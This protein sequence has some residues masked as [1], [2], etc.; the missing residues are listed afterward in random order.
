MNSFTIS[1]KHLDEV[2]R[3]SK[4][5]CDQG[6]RYWMSIEQES[7]HNRWYVFHLYCTEEA[8]KSILK[9]LRIKM[10]GVN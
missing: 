9:D 10:K 5:L 3:Y 2:E 6:A 8:F 4:Y 1:T 7:R